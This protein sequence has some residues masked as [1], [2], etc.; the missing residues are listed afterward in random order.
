MLV[1]P[2]FVRDNDTSI[3]THRFLKP[4][5]TPKMPSAIQVPPT[6]S[7]TDT[8]ATPLLNDPEP[9]KR[10]SVTRPSNPLPKV[11]LSLTYLIRVVDPLSNN[12]VYPFINQML[13]DL[14][15]ANSPETVGY[16]NGLVSSNETEGIHSHAGNDGEPSE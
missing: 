11:Q 12:V 2:W 13:V 8:E 6:M 10:S 9:N 3:L 5:A 7:E 4:G 1:S 16:A 14:G 15:A